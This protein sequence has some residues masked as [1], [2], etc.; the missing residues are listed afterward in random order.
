MATP[1][2]QSVDSLRRQIGAERDELAAAIESLRGEL[3]LEG[4]LRAR[5]PLALIGA[6]GAGF[7]V[8]GGIGATFR[9]VFRRGRER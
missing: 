4:K 8:S 3:E 1:E 7:V 9:L 2:P 6:L 5:L